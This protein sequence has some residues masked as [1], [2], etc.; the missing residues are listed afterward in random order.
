TAVRTQ[1]SLVV[2]AD[3]N[4]RLLRGLYL[5]DSLRDQGRAELTR[6]RKL[7]ALARGRDEIWFRIGQRFWRQGDLERAEQAW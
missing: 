3:E 4:K 2:E 6:Y 5:T 7:A 1:K